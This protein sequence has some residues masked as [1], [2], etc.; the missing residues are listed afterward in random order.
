[1]TFSIIIWPE[2]D[3]AMMQII[4][5]LSTDVKDQRWIIDDDFSQSCNNADL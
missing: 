3:G 2:E 5:G 1:M 4:A